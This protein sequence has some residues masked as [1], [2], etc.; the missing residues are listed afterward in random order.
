MAAERPGVLDAVLLRL[1]RGYQRRVS[2]SLGP[3]CRYQPTCSNYAYEAIERYGSL[4]GAWLAL[5]RLVRCTPFG[6][7]GWDPVP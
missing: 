1:I 5:T 6:R 7:G 3:L 2:P 4:K